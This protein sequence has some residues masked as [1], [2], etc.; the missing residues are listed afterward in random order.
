[1]I[2]FDCLYHEI[3]LSTCLNTV[4]YLTYIYSTSSLEYSFFFF[5]F[6]FFYCV[7]FSFLFFLVVLCWY[8]V[9]HAKNDANRSRGAKETSRGASRDDEKSRWR[10]VDI[11]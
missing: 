10:Y 8:D 11:I 5:Y 2:V 4:Q 6:S 3:Y 1:M 7:L 9:S